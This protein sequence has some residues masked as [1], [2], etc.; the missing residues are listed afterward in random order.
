[1]KLIAINGSPRKS[2]NT[3]TLLNSALEGAASI[4]AST[5]IVHLYDLDYKGCISCF[6]C[7]RRGGSSYGKCAVRDGLTPLLEKIEGADAF[8]IGSPIYFGN[9]TGE[10]RSFME[11]L[12]FQYLVYAREDRSLAP[13]KRV[14]LIFTMNL[15]DAMAKD[16]GYDYIFEST[17]RT[18]RMLFGSA[19]I[20]CATDT[21]Q[22]EDYSLYVAPLFNEMEKKRRHEEEFPRDCKRAFDLGVKF[23]GKSGSE[24]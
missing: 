2:W 1:M 4:G 24:S 13:K 9:V 23:A 7:K 19:E 8:F 12:L 11:R 15:S 5:E 20:L 16:R 18:F 21:L 3:A 10:T 6:A 14:G 17:A 22:F